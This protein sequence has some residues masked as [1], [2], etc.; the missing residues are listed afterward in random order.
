MQRLSRAI[1]M[2]EKLGKVRVKLHVLEAFGFYTL[3]F[4]ILEFAF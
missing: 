1:L 2:E 3:K 4:Q